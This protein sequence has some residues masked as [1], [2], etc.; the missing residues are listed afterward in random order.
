[1]AQVTAQRQ[2]VATKPKLTQKQ[3]TETV[4]VMLYT[5]AS[6]LCCMRNIFPALAFDVVEL[7]EDDEFY[8]FENLMNGKHPRREQPPSPSS[9]SARSSEPKIPKIPLLKRGRSIRADQFLDALNTAFEALHRG[10]LHA[11]RIPFMGDPDVNADSLEL[12]SFRVIYKQ[13]PESGREVQGLEANLGNEETF[14][15][16]LC[17]SDLLLRVEEQCKT[18][19]QLPDDRYIQPSILYKDNGWEPKGYVKTQSQQS[20]E[21]FAGWQP[22]KADLGII[23]GLHHDFAL[24]VSALKHEHSSTRRI[25]QDLQSRKPGANRESQLDSSPAALAGGDSPIQTRTTSPTSRRRTS[26]DSAI[27]ETPRHLG[28]PDKDR[29]SPADSHALTEATNNHVLNAAG[30][31]RPN[32]LQSRTARPAT[33]EQLQQHDYSSASQIEDDIRRRNSLENMLKPSSNRED[34]FVTQVRT[35]ASQVLNDENSPSPELAEHVR[36]Y[37]FLTSE[38]AYRLWIRNSELQTGLNTNESIT[39]CRCQ[40]HDSM[41]DMARCSICGVQQHSICQGY[42][43]NVRQ[44]PQHICHLCLFGRKI[45]RATLAKLCELALQ[46]RVMDLLLSGDIDNTVELSRKLDM[47]FDKVTALV[48][49]LVSQKFV[50]E[51]SGRS[52]RNSQGKITFPKSVSTPEYVDSLAKLFDPYQVVGHHFSD[53]AVSDDS[54][55]NVAQT[56]RA[57]Y[58]ILKEVP[59][60]VTPGVSPE[61]KGD[62]T[63]NASKDTTRSAT[64]TTK[65]RSRTS[66]PEAVETSEQATPLRQSPRVTTRTPKMTEAIFG[67]WINGQNLPS[68]EHPEIKSKRFKGNS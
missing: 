4:Q 55:V 15:P 52:T 37:N 63:A 34:D 10:T 64:T 14:D 59:S 51:Q 41:D 58:T 36:T 67:Y 29:V 28:Q 7:A 33:S 40:L 60:I 6:L 53:A 50:E 24:R 17:I 49:S 19:P 68:R 9:T 30:L 25:S 61:H 48:T 42:L 31:L 20:V 57:R 32:V 47:Q 11:L 2:I 56:L 39:S 35:S 65:K 54:D 62:V 12:W 18:L 44:P 23:S 46:R 38:T 43:G 66:Q 3:S 8:T 45:D 21:G 22:Y 1:M 16:S 5:S 13:S 26:A 27:P